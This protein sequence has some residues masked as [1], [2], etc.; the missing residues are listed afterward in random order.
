MNDA[1]RPRVALVF[2]GVLGPAAYYAGA[3]EAFSE[4]GHQPDWVTG[5]RSRD[6]RTCAGSAGWIA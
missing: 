5:S 1:S 4:A 3:Y 2:A 6:S